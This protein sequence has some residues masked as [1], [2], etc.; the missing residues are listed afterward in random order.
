MP[1]RVEVPGM[2][3]VEFPDGMSDDQISAAIRANMPK[4]APVPSRMEMFKREIMGSLPVQTALGAVRGAGSIGATLMAPF[5]VAEQAI[6]RRLGAPERAVS[7][8][9]QR[10]DGITGGLQQLGADPSSAGFQIGKV[11]GEIAGTLG[12]GPALA[13]AAGGTRLAAA[14]PGLVEAVRTAGMSAGG[15][16]GAAGLGLRTVGGGVAGGVSAGLVS[17]DDAAFGAGVGAVLPGAL[18]GLGTAGAAVGRQLRGGKA[19]ATESLARALDAN[20][21][22]DAARIAAQLRQAREL[23]PGSKPTA[24]QVLRTPQASILE[25]VVADSAGGVAL[26]ERELAQN[27]ARLAAI[28]RVAPTNPLGAA[29]ARDEFGRALSEF[30]AATDKSMRAATRAR[31]QAIPQDEA[32]LYLPDLGAIRDDVFGRGSILNRDGLDRVVS[33]AQKIGTME[34]PAM[35]AA[36]ATQSGA[37]L[38]LAQAVRRAGGVTTNAGER[39]GELQGLKGD[40]KNLI[41]ST[42]L[43]PGRMAQKMYEAGYLAD[44]G[45]DTLIDALKTDARGGPQFSRF[46]LPEQQWAAARDAAMGAAPGAQAV[47]QKVTLGEFDNLRKDIGS[48]LRAAKADPERA[49]EAAAL[50]QMKQA[51]DDRINE[52]V[53]GDGAIDEVLPIDWANA[54]DEARKLKI[55]QVKTTGTGP[56]AAALARGRDGLPAYQGAELARQAWWQGVPPEDVAQLR[57][58]IDKN[59]RLLEQF[60]SMVS[61]EGAGTATDAG[62]LSGKFV[63]WVENTLPGLKAAFDP[64]QVKTMQRVALDIRRSIQAAAAGSAKGSPTYANA[65][66]ALSLGL[67]DSPVLNVAANRLPLIGQFTGAGLDWM[68]ESARTSRATELAK[69]L[70]DPELAASALEGFRRPSALDRLFAAPA[71]GLALRA[72]PVAT[73]VDR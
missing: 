7:L 51:L 4:P 10:R 25:R 66:N 11:G 39:V 48:M 23:V 40:L 30:T 62:R 70:A 49:R 64:E 71:S 34:L 73:T 57:V 35:Q 52:V 5:D 19:K 41:R 2:G 56:Q 46:D 15:A 31:Y 45:I 59:P 36:K 47:P 28:E 44:D 27:A 63:R 68:R 58:L 16:K 55:E 65:S 33:E 69:L 17:P 42:G 29:S 38:T 3:I 20:N 54:L 60:R 72:I 43:S 24:A 21:P 6:E 12:V 22:Q 1:Q 61:T 67:L 13:T 26:K 18:Q 53:R 14:A 37:P 9:Q 50:T 8:N 32:A